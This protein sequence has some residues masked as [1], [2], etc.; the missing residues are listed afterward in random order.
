MALNPSALATEPKRLTPP[1]PGAQRRAVLA[2]EV[3]QVKQDDRSRVVLR[4]KDGD[5]R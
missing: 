4:A 1:L 2:C 5:V 3:E